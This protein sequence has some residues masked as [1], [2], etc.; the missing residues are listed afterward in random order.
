MIR[1]LLVD[2]HETI[3]LGLTAMLE[4]VDDIA[5]V[6][7]ARD[8]HEA[9][10]LADRLQPDVI[11]M[12]LSLGTVDGFDATE[13]ILQR[14]PAARVVVL[15]SF[16]RPT[17]VDQALRAGACGYLVKGE[18]ATNVTVAIRHAHDGGRPLSDSLVAGLRRLRGA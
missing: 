8:G 9:V 13:R 12:D 7:C 16:G 15:S 18:S 3:L 17:M 1:V 11:V 10:H 14:D 2:D 6:G 4:Q 5:V